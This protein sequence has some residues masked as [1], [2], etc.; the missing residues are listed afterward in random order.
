MLHQLGH[1][2][3]HNVVILRL[4]DLVPVFRP[5]ALDARR[6]PWDEGEKIVGD[7][8]PWYLPLVSV[9]I[10]EYGAA[11]VHLE[12]DCDGFVQSVMSGTG[13]LAEVPDFLSPRSR[14]ATERSGPAARP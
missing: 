9:L 10:E 3:R 13:W 14:T 6:G 4:T 1:R 11:V 5:R 12:R 7:I 2:Q 8:G